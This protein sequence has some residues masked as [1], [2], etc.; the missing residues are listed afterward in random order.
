MKKLIA[1]LL[2]LLCVFGTVGCNMQSRKTQGSELLLKGNVIKV[3]VSSLP[4]GYNYSFNAEKAKNITD[5]LSDLKLQSNFE[6]NP[7]DYVGMTWVIILEYEKGNTVTIYHFGNMFIRSEK[8][9]WYKM[10][11]EDAARFSDLL[12]TLDN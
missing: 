1:F 7:N 2:T 9:P 8:G 11:N 12:E 10:T 3:S 4:E 5:Y 6:E